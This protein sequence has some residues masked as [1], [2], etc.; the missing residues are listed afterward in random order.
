[1]TNKHLVA[2]GLSVMAATAW[3][4]VS[5]SDVRAECSWME[6]WKNNRQPL[7]PDE[8]FH[9]GWMGGIEALEQAY[10]KGDY[11]SVDM[12]AAENYHSWSEPGYMEDPPH[13]PCG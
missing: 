8:H 6:N 13:T 3:T 1:M 4:S 7:L 9:Q 10:G 12:Y 5:A 11:E 2:L